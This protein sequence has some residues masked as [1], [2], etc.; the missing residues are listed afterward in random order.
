MIGK[1]RI[2]L[3]GLA[4]FTIGSAL[5]GAAPSLGI[6]IAA[7]LFQGLGGALIFAVNVA[8]LTSVFPASER[9]RALGLNAVVVALGI[10]AGPTIGGII[11]QNFT[12]PLSFYVNLP[13][14]ILLFFLFL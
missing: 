1:T 6:L 3:A 7:R 2:W 13:F 9:G 5:S 11:T 8:L 14:G 12:W 4:I 10:S